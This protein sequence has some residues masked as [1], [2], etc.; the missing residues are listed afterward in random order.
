MS[1][2]LVV[3]D[4]SAAVAAEVAERLVVLLSSR[5]DAG[6]VPSV[7]LTGGTIAA[8]IH[9]AVRTVRGAELVDWSRVDV[10]FGDERFLPAGHADRNETQARD[11]LL[12]AV[13]LDPARVHAMPADQGPSGTGEGAEVAARATEAAAEHA[14]DVRQAASAGFDLVMLGLGP[15]G[16]VASLFP[17]HETL[18][19]D[20]LGVLTEPDSPKPPPVRLSMT[21]PTLRTGREV[22]FVVSGEDKAD[23]VRRAR[24]GDDVAT[25]PGA[26]VRG[27]DAT[28]WFADSAAASLLDVR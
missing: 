10:W 23:A 18:Q 25:T 11:A 1:E 6:E 15:D 8:K 24:A 16:H 9:S 13:P 28:R 3:L 17:G 21:L 27:V 12:D 4:A 2:E 19:V 26:G 22:W 20:Q 14:A 7:V 5:Q